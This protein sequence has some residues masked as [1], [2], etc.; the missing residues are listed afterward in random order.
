MKYRGLQG[1]YEDSD[2]KIENDV[3]GLGYAKNPKN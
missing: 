3:F 1:I 2:I